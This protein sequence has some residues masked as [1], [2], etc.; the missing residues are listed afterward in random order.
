[1]VGIVSKRF[2]AVVGIALFLSVAACSNPPTTPPLPPTA[3]LAYYRGDLWTLPE[4]FFVSGEDGDNVAVGAG[5]DPFTGVSDLQ[6]EPHGAF[7]GFG[8]FTN[9]GESYSFGIRERGEVDLRESRL[10]FR[11]TNNTDEHVVGF[12]LGFA[13]EV[14]LRGERANRIRLKF[15]T[16]TDGFGTLPDIISVT[17]PRGRAT[18]AAV[19]EVVDGSHPENRSVVDIRVL[20]SEVPNGEGGFFGSLEPGDTG[21]FR[22]QYSNSDGDSGKLRSALALSDIRI[23]PIY[24]SPPTPETTS[25]LHFSHGA[26]FYS[27]PFMLTLSSAWPGAAIY[28][29][30]DGSIPDPAQIMDDSTWATLPVESRTRTFRYAVPIDLEELTEREAEISLI[31]TTHAWPPWSR[32][33]ERPYLGTVVRAVAVDDADRSTLLTNTYF[34]T[35]HGRDRYTLPV[36]SLATDRANLFSPDSG[37]YVPGSSGENYDERGGAWERP[38]HIE[39]WEGGEHRALS[40]DAGAR[41]HGGYTRQLPQKALRLYARK[42]YGES[43]F[44]YP[45]FESKPETEF[46]RLIVRAGGNDYGHA[47][48]RDAAL[49]TLVQHLPFETQHYRPLILFI[50]GE[51][52]GLHEFRDRYDDHHLA[53][54]Y[55]LER[56]QITLLERDAQLEAGNAEDAAEYQEFI[57]RV[58]RGKFRSLADFDAQMDLHGF[59]DYMVAQMYAA[60][61]DWPDNNIMFWRYSGLARSDNPFTDGRWRWLMYD[62]DWSFGNKTTYQTD[63]LKS[64][65]IDSQSDWSRTLISGLMDIYEIRHEAIQRIA[66][67]LATTF[68]PERVH[69]H[70]DSLAAIIEPEMEEQVQRWHGVSTLSAWRG[71]LGKMHEFAAMRPAHFRQHVIDHFDEV[72]GTAELRIEGITEGKGVA[73]YTVPLSARIPGVGIEGGV[74][75]G[76]L[77]TGIP[78]VLKA[79]G[80][81]LLQAVLSGEVS[82]VSRSRDELSFIMTGPAQIELPAP[83]AEIR[84]EEIRE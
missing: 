74:W 18:G 25:P 12:D 54:R 47:H 48:L 13:V 68:R 3:D 23:T 61:T 39:F 11:Y 80:T 51:Y 37:I 29:T 82:E 44:A 78:V 57:A 14:W 50:N 59:L 58:G 9:G 35:P 31:P 22:W 75:K 55:G 8:A 34:I 28:Y 53:T 33:R 84:I 19:G 77:F 27:E 72:I 52:W 4:G 6:G 40:Q 73:L 26:G 49:Q 38:V 1:V 63:M 81:D 16:E 7:D 5:F 46:K 17:N 83:G 67:H 15:N 56:D 2:P 36:M 62:V 43:R 64:L 30:V 32:P 10:F 21:Y 76:E 42:E 60:N 20:L 79:A 69:A 41:I 65:L 24:G 71:E 66:V 70:I 45:F